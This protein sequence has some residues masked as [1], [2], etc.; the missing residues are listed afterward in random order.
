MSTCR[1]IATMLTAYA[2]GEL[3]AFERRRVEAHLEACAACR[4]E[5]HRE[6]RLR[7]R[8]RALPPAVCPDRVVAAI[9]A[10][11]DRD[12]ARRRVLA[13]VRPRRLATAALA[14]AAL[15][16]LVLLPSRP[17]LPAD[18]PWTADRAPADTEIDQARQEVVRALAYTAVLLDRTEQ[19][20]RDDM[21]RML[22]PALEAAGAADIAPASTGGQG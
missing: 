15:L 11:V 12:Q 19:R 22:Q 4:Q 1:H 17:D 2:G 21:L 10:A 6:R 20:V 13:P 14:A 7:E 3:S 9:T 8:M 5:L 18:A 16:L